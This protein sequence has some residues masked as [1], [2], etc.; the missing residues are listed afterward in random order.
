MKEGK[1]K[2]DWLAI[3]FESIVNDKSAVG[4]LLEADEFVE[5]SN[6]I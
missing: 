4:I 2:A 1:A 6:S 5:Y 3:E